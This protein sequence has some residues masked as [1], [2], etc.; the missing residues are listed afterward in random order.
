MVSTSESIPDK[1]ANYDSLEN[2]LKTI[3]TIL[4]YHKQELI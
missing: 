1:I 4:I 2:N 3:V